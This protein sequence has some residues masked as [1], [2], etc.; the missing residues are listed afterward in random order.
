MQARSAKAQRTNARY[1]TTNTALETRVYTKGYLFSSCGAQKTKIHNYVSN[2]YM[3]AVLT[4]ISL[5]SQGMCK[6]IF[7]QVPADKLHGVSLV[8]AVQ[9]V[10]FPWLA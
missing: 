6:T 1:Q 7:L 5:Y 9:A 3:L 10:L 8:F 4:T 2:H